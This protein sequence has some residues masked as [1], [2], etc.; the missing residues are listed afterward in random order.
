MDK[1]IQYLTWSDVGLPSYLINSIKESENNSC[2]NYFVLNR[3]FR[4]I[5]KPQY[6]YLCG[7]CDYRKTLTRVYEEYSVCEDCGKTH[8]LHVTPQLRMGRDKCRPFKD[9]ICGAILRQMHLNHLIYYS[10]EA[11]KDFFRSGWKYNALAVNNEYDEDNLYGDTVNAFG[12]FTSGDLVEDESHMMAICKSAILTPFLW[13]ESF[14][15]RLRIHREK[16]K[17]THI[18]PLIYMFSKF[19][20]NQESSHI[21]L[22]MPRIDYERHERNDRNDRGDRDDGE[23]R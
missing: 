23:R 19:K 18:T 11:P 5:P 3:V 22:R 15:W 12:Q 8:K 6:Y 9:H 16:S 1:S 7:S 21:E 2:I 4:F 17:H 10:Q 13:D 20:L 14:D